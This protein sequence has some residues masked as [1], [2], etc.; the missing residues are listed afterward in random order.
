MLLV[1][2]VFALWTVTGAMDTLMW[3]LYAAYDRDETRG[4]VKRRL[5]AL[6]MVVC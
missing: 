1:G 3:A 6:A 4:F 2:S 5:I